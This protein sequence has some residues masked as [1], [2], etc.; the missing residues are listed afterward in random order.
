MSK[1][2]PQKPIT[3]GLMTPREVAEFGRI[4]TRTVRRLVAEG[5]LPVVLYRPAHSLTRM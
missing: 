5:L 1:R 2:F 4:S 3:E